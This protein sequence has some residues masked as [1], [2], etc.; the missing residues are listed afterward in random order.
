MPGEKFFERKKPRYYKEPSEEDIVEKGQA[1]AEIHSGIRARVIGSRVLAAT[2]AAGTGTAVTIAEI[3]SNNDIRPVDLLV[4][5]SIPVAFNLF[6]EI[7]VENNLRRT[8]REI[9]EIL[10]D[11]LERSEYSDSIRKQS[12]E[13]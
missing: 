12:E 10:P 5:F 9:S 2:V 3:W 8:E 4:N 7:K 13:K 11:F 1:L 6:A